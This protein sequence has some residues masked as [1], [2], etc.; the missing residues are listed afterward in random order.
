[1]WKVK[2]E[3]VIDRSRVQCLML[4]LCLCV[5]VCVCVGGCCGWMLPSLW[6]PC[7]AEMEMLEKGERIYCPAL[8]ALIFCRCFWLFSRA[9]P[10]LLPG[11]PHHVCVCAIQKERQECAKREK[12]LSPHCSCKSC[13]LGIKRRTKK[14][15]DLNHVSPS[16]ILNNFWKTP[17][18]RL[19]QTLR[20]HIHWRFLFQRVMFHRRRLTRP[21]FQ[22]SNQLII[23]SSTFLSLWRD[24]RGA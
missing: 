20:E 18:R 5:H 11:R 13:W 24:S 12:D 22:L 1:M 7:L 2:C 14:I 10:A 23:F 15:V 4:D 17:R 6:D 21:D 9:M 3:K 16:L 19:A 8:E